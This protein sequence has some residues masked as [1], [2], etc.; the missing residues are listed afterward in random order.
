MQERVDKAR[1][2]G[3]IRIPA[4]KSHTIRAL[5]FATLAEG[6]SR[7]QNPLDSDDTRSCMAAC[8]LLGANIVPAPGEFIV[9][10]TAGKL[11]VPEDIIN[12]GNSG[13]TMYLA[14]GAAALSP[15]WSFFTGDHQIRKRSIQHLL[16]SIAELG[17]EN[18]TARGNGCAPFAIRGP[19]RGGKTS[20]ESHT[21]QF[22]SSLLM[23]LPLVESDSE[24]AVPILNERPYVEM[25]LGWLDE[26]GITYEQQDMKLFRIP[27]RQQYHGFRRQVPADFSSATFFLCAAAITRSTLTLDGLNMNDTQGDKG[28][29]D[30][31]EKMGCTLL[32][33]ESG[34]TI[35]GKEMVGGTFDLNSMPDA[36]PALAATACYATTETRLV[37][38]P[39]A[40][41]KETDR[42]HVMA[43]ELRRMGAQIEETPDG[44]II[45]PSQ[46]KGDFVN[47][48]GDHRI[49]MALAIAGLGATGST[50]IDTAE[51]ASVTFPTFFDDLRS[52]VQSSL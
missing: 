13:T 46:L 50:I 24:I 4:S 27:G 29:V 26:L 51:S 8:R 22:L 17:A 21:S 25:T 34:I 10:G 44:L 15:G 47:G 5:I 16:N 52:V 35:T 28:V 6:R 1:L 42:I 43:E 38:V 20:I 45:Q 3:R 40:R 18:F 37:N 2:A 49:V 36:L 41:G 31:L 39:N 9:D 7:I 14:A 48:N 23:S 32:I 33:E 11:T 12:V 19:L 30:I